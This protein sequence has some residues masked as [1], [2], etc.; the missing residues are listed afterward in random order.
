MKKSKFIPK[1]VFLESF[2][3]IHINDTDDYLKV[4]RDACNY[5]LIS[6]ESGD[7]IPLENVKGIIK[8]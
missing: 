8:L 1:R 4:V 7:V 2:I 6:R 3:T 5:M